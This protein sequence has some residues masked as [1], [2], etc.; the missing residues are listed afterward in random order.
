MDR[1]TYCGRVLRHVDKSSILRKALHCQKAPE[2]EH[3]CFKFNLGIRSFSPP[4]V[5][6]KEAL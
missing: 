1:I 4:A 5:H 6:V 3:E 2:T